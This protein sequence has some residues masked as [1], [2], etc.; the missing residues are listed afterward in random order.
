MYALRINIFFNSNMPLYFAWRIKICFLLLKSQCVLV[1]FFWNRSIVHLSIWSLSSVIFFPEEEARKKPRILYVNAQKRLA[2]DKW[3]KNN[4]N[5]NAEF[6]EHYNVVLST[7]FLLLLLSNLSFLSSSIN[8]MHFIPHNNEHLFHEIREN[9]HIGKRWIRKQ[10]QLELFESLI[11]LAVCTC[12]KCDR[13]AFTWCILYQ[14]KFNVY[15][16]WQYVLFFMAI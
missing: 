5:C 3:W 7:T 10:T 2:C 14:I 4:G 12:T 13:C 6:I 16:S 9:N 8:R 15:E 11:H 1:F